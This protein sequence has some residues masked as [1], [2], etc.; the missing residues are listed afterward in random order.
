M[1]PIL[2]HIISECLKDIKGNSSIS[3]PL[4]QKEYLEEKYVNI[5]VQINGKKKSLIKSEKNLDE[6]KL[7]K[8]VLKDEKILNFLGKRS[9]FKHIIIK[10]KLVNLIIK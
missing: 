9:V 10:N 8:N 6:E 3:W 7:L 2:P 1:F 4:A 5:V